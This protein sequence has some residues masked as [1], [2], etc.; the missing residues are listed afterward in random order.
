MKL[1]Q[2]LESTP[3]WQHK[4][5]AVRLKSLQNSELESSQ[6][7]NLANND[8]DTAVRLCAIGLLEDIP[9]LFSLQNDEDAK[10]VSA[11]LTR[12]AE[13]VGAD[14]KL[15]ASN[16]SQLTTTQII[17]LVQG[18]G[19]LTV[20]CQSA[21]LL[22]NE[23]ELS[24]IL[25]Q[26]NHTKVHQLCAEK[27]VS[28]SRLEQIQ[29]QFLHKDKNVIK[30]VKQKLQLI[31][32][33]R[34]QKLDN[35]KQFEKCR[36][37]IE[38]LAKAEYSEEFSRRFEVLVEQ[39]THLNEV[40]SEQ[41][42]ENDIDS[43]ITHEQVASLN[44]TFERCQEIITESKDRAERAAALSDQA[45]SILSDLT[46][47]S[48]QVSTSSSEIKRVLKEAMGLYPNYSESTKFK[49]QKKDLQELVDQHEIWERIQGKLKSYAPS[50]Q[51]KA[52]KEID[53]PE[54]F[55]KPVE[56][57]VT[58]NYAT[59]AQ[60]K[61]I[62]SESGKKALLDNLQHQLDQL[63]RAIEDGKLKQ[64]QK[65]HHALTSQTQNLP[66]RLAS[67]LESLTTKL[68]DLQDWQGYATIP[69]REALCENMSAL[70]K[71]DTITEAEKADLIK[72]LQ[73]QWKDLGASDSP[74]AQKLW[75]R[76]RKL[77]EIAYEPCAAYFAK[78]KS[79]RDNNL[80]EKEKIC[81]ALE[82]LVKDIDE[83]SVNWKTRDW[84]NL[85]DVI[86][87]VQKEWRRFDEISRSKYKQIQNRY[88]QV[89]DI[90]Y[91]KLKT[92]KAEN[93]NVKT[94]LIESVQKLALSD[95]D[96]EGINVVDLIEKTKTIQS[97]WKAVGITDRKVDQKLWK[98]F[99]AACDQVFSLRATAEQE[100]KD[101]MEELYKEARAVCQ[102]L[103]SLIDSDATIQQSD[104]SQ[105]KKAFY[106]LGN[107]KALKGINQQ[108]LR[109]IKE[110][111]IVIEDQKQSSHKDKMHELKRK[112]K[113]CEAFEL[114]ERSY[115]SVQ[116]LWD[117]NITL[118]VPINKLIS[119]RLHKPKKIDIELKE[120][121][122]IRLEILADIES[123]SE[124]Q[125][126]RMAYQVERLKKELSMGIKETRSIPEQI[127]EIQILW[128]SEVIDPSTTHL[129]KR[130]S[131]AEA[132]LGA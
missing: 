109:L 85:T 59:I 31:K 131:I 81:T 55:F 101:Q 70:A 42:K 21:A 87:E 19:L 65:I 23:D 103:Q 118:D 38:R 90:L 26:Q 3:K 99:R 1:S 51:L 6:V 17:A 120:V 95:I 98:E 56:I 104:I 69:K 68:R 75:G 49:T 39:R 119:K 88:K 50:R 2:I 71:N 108:L 48:R 20:K 100:E 73:Q 96:A 110:A 43:N 107:E 29:K 10:I 121:L 129:S 111:N 41:V 14:T 8:E 54:Q 66:G 77:G 61:L 18:A 58:Y 113:L 76:F 22:S 79:L 7:S 128:Y 112:A 89:L 32:S 64:A 27:L 74:K 60:E 44:L 30:I 93:H 9:S 130:Y 11:S 127:E 117:N 34:V 132:K 125:Q 33:E 24:Q 5:A 92:E 80:I 83:T 94:G 13:L 105:C 63:T 114:G 53:W 86:N 4:D 36:E 28:E 123:P 40:I 122:C 67:T 84:K 45:M 37:A 72:E 82:S 62:E 35:L 97:E 12:W 16:S 115:E 25:H 78:Q 102:S 57:E 106:E 15:F 124:S 126:A 46:L 52:L 91:G 47:S 116:A